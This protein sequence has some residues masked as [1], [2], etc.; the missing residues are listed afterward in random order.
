MLFLILIIALTTKV[1]SSPVS[2]LRED[3]PQETTPLL[4]PS[5]SDEEQPQDSDNESEP[6]ESL[7]KHHRVLFI[8]T[9]ISLVFAIIGITLL[10]VTT[11]MLIVGYPGYGFDEDWPYTQFVHRIAFAVSTSCFSIVG[12]PFS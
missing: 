3:P 12:G 2:Q 4:Q 10:I 1:M 7:S 6:E 5:L 11:C 9:I 8:G